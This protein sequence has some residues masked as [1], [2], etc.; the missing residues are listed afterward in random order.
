VREYTSRTLSHV[1]DRLSAMAGLWRAD[2]FRQLQSTAMSA[3][4][5]AA[6]R[7]PTWSCASMAGCAVAYKDNTDNSSRQRK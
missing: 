1:S 2:L 6:Y 4:Q 5:H 3:T 7:A